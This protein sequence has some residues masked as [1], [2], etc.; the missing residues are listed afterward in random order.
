MQKRSQAIWGEKKEKLLR[1]QP[2]PDPGGGESPK[3]AFCITSR[4]PFYQPTRLRNRVP[5]LSVSH[6]SV[7]V[8]HYTA[9]ED[10]YS[11]EVP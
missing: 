10:F 6:P 7:F 8:Q 3:A 11:S 9:E 1:R 5:T 4:D 2:L